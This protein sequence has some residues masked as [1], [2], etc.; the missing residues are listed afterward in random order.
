MTVVSNN[1][2]TLDGLVHYIRGIGIAAEGTRLLENVDRTA[3]SSTALVLFPDDFPEQPV[4]SALLEL[5][6][7][8]PSLLVVLVTAMPARYAGMRAVRAGSAPLVVPKPVWGSALLDLIRERLEEL[9]D[10]SRQGRGR[11]R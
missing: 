2:E 8:C 9:A 11:K 3:A 4:L 1:P 7:R 6:D 10:E 5:G